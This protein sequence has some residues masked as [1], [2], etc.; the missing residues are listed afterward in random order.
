MNKYTFLQKKE[1]HTT[2]SAFTFKAENDNLIE[3][4]ITDPRLVTITKNFNNKNYNNNDEFIVEFLST[5]SNIFFDFEKK[6]NFLLFHSRLSRKDFSFL[7]IF[8]K[9]RNIFLSFKENRGLVEAIEII[10][11]S[12]VD[13]KIVDCS[14]KTFNTYAIFPTSIFDFAHCMDI[15]TGEYGEYSRDFYI[16]NELSYYVSESVLILECYREYSSFFLYT[17]KKDILKYHSLYNLILEFLSE[18][19]IKLKDAGTCDYSEILQNY[20]DFYYSD[21][22]ELEFLIMF[23]HFKSFLNFHHE[24]LKSKK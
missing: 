10:N 16:N 20:V 18:N 5:I 13:S 6:R 2:Y 7:E 1:K 8:C 11:P 9:N 15:S 4:S 22:Y 3:F 19:Q 14:I 24:C 17:F 12:I 23:K 21:E